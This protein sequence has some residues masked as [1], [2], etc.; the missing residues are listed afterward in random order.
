VAFIVKAVSKYT[1]STTWAIVCQWY[2]PRG[3][4]DK[5]IK[6]RPVPLKLVVVYV[7]N[8]ENHS[9]CYKPVTMLCFIIINDTYRSGAKEGVTRVSQYW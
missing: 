5:A 3:R 8:S 6:R 4:I 7:R 9:A 2:W 1:G